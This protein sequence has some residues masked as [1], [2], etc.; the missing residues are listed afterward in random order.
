M[1][2][3]ILLID[4]YNSIYRSNVSFG[5]QDK[6]KI[7]YT[8]VYN[9]FR[10]LRSNVEKFG[11]TKVF[12]C[13]EGKNN[14]RYSLL[15]SYKANRIVKQASEKKSDSFLRQKD[16]ILKLL[17]MLPITKVFATGYEADD[18]IA[19]LVNNINGTHTTILST[20]SD[21]IQ[22]LQN[23]IKE[24]YLYDPDAKDYVNPPNFHY[25]LWKILRGD[26]T[27]NVPRIVND[28]QVDALVK[29]PAELSK[30]LSNEENKSHFNLNKQ[31]IELKIIPNEDLVLSDGCSN[32]ELLKEEFLKME[33]N[34]ML[35]NKYWSRFVETFEG[36]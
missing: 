3:K 22:L 14:F 21:Y 15:P 23:D 5:K 4:G 34:S 10:A 1:E 12:F 35:T 6:D 11:P 36:L 2:E 7:S 29:A 33:F 27:D 17:E 31:L 24:L 28:E 26:K 19:T 25:L 9:F 20:D 8:I 32:F 18:V 16:I 30:F 13:L